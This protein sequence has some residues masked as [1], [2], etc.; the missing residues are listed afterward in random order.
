MCHGL[1]G[2]IIK[3]QTSNLKLQASS[4]N[5][6]SARQQRAL[7]QQEVFYLSRWTSWG[8]MRPPSRDVLCAAHVRF[9]ECKILQ[10][11]SKL[12][13]TP[14][15]LKKPKRVCYPCS[16]EWIDQW[17]SF[18]NNSPAHGQDFQFWKCKT[19]TSRQ[20]GKIDILMEKNI[21]M[22]IDKFFRA[23]ATIFD[24]GIN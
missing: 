19:V 24:R 8:D 6:S 16:T 1:V 2:A 7:K 18:V 14:T 9:N 22:K 23:M 21:Y 15:H 10:S 17:M 20:K 4:P 12:S 3:P 11:F 13:I 5:N